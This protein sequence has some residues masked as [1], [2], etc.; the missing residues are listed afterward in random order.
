MF[1]PSRS[2][3]LNMLNKRCVRVTNTISDSNRLPRE[4]QTHTYILTQT[5]ECKHLLFIHT[6]FLL[7]I[8]TRMCVSVRLYVGR[9]LCMCVCLFVH[10]VCVSVWVWRDTLQPTS[11]KLQCFKCTRK[12]L[13][14]SVKR[15]TC[16][17]EHMCWLNDIFSS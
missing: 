7:A 8:K 5:H 12:A 3:L 2:S 4:T 14:Y 9:C 11:E 6:F 17:C 10:V 1:E 16:C 15:S 13:G